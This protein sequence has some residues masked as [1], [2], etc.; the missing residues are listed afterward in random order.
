MSSS[1]NIKLCF[2]NNRGLHWNFGGCESFLESNCFDILAL[3]ETNLYDSIDSGNFFVRGYLLLI[4]EDS[5][6]HMHGLAIYVIE[7]LPFAQGLSLENS[8]DTYLCFWLALLHSAFYFFFL[9][10]ISSSL[11]T[12]FDIILSNIDEVL[13]TNPSANLFAFENINVHHKDQPTHS[14]GI[15][16]ADMLHYNFL[17]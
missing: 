11:C 14:G 6:I 13:S 16:R 15:D 4:W 2:T 9:L 5:V 3:S 1:L 10:L 7:G 17:S 12:V 8:W